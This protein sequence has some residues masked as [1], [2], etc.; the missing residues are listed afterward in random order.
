MYEVCPPAVSIDSGQSLQTACDMRGERGLADIFQSL[1]LTN[2]NPM[3]KKDNQKG[4]FIS[5]YIYTKPTKVTK[6]AAIQG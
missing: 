3:G 2:Q 6:T 4:K 1:Q 5:M